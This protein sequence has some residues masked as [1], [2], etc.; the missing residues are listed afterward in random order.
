MRW[1]GAGTP[2]V[3]GRAQGHVIVAGLAV[4]VMALAGCSSTKQ[5]ARP[6]DVVEFSVDGPTG[7]AFG[8]YVLVGD[9]LGNGTRSFTGIPFDIRLPAPP[10]TVEPKMSISVV[11]VPPNSLVTCRITMNGRL[12]VQN[13]APVPGPN[14]V[15]VAPSTRTR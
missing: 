2:G 1:R 10:P 13:T 14:V 9:L 8:T 7:A 11:D 3:C 12:L 4:L 15:C 5:L 6:V